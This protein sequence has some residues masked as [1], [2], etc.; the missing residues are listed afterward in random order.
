M[1]FRCPIENVILDTDCASP[2]SQ[3]SD[4]FMSFT[5]NW[6]FAACLAAL[7]AA[8]TFADDS[9]ALEPPQL[10][11]LKIGDQS[12]PIQEGKPVDLTGSF[13]NPQIELVPRP[14][15]LFVRRGIQFEYPRQ[16]T[17]E[18]DLKSPFSKSWTL[19]GNDLKLMVFAMTVPVTPRQ[20]G[21][22]VMG[23]L[24]KD[25]CEITE[26]QAEL[27]LGMERLKGVK[28]IA[29]VAEQ[30]ISFE[31]YDLPKAGRTSRL[32]TIQDNPDENGDRSAE[33]RAGMELLQ[34]SFKLVP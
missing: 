4:E 23:T 18:A 11:E 19:S 9:E 6:I 15:R 13:T 3:T 14:T 8:P 17:F 34:K 27:V 26:P 28:F 5:R 31:I 22:N 30:H 33:G 10:Y 25:H 2:R 7:V 32:L 20:F 24:G 12:V 1:I 21:D 16:F 29:S